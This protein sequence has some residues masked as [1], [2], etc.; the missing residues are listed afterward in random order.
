M[1]GF[2]SPAT[3]LCA[4]KH[5]LD[6]DWL[7]ND[8]VEASIRAFTAAVAFVNSCLNIFQESLPDIRDIIV[9]ALIKLFVLGAC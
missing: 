3:F 6:S 4:E 7:L 9:I 8:L 5:H 1:N 2:E